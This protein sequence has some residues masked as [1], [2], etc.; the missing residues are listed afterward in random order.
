MQSTTVHC[1][2]LLLLPQKYSYSLTYLLTYLLQLLILLLLQLQPILLRLMQKYN[3]DFNDTVLTF[4]TLYLVKL[5]IQCFWHH[6][7]L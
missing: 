6:L 3:T 5:R 2:P 4:N 1:D 7:R